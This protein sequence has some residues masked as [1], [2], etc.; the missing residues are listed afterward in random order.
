MIQTIKILKK[1]VEAKK[2]QKGQKLIIR[3]NERRNL[4]LEEVENED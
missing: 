1:I 3:F 4:E 2:W